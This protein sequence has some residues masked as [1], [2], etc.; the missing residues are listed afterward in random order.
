MLFADVSRIRHSA[1]DAGFLTRTP[2]G[3]RYRLATTD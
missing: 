1:V 2:D 3:A